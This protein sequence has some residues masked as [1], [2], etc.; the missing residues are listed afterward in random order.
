MEWGHERT[1]KKQLL[2]SGT[3]ITG[4]SVFSSAAAPAPQPRKKIQ[5][6]ERGIID[7]FTL[8]R[9]RWRMIVGVTLLLF[10]AGSAVIMTLP[11]A[12]RADVLVVLQ[13]ASVNTGASVLTQPDIRQRLDALREQVES[14][15]TLDEVIK[16]YDLYSNS[17]G[18]TQ[19]D[20]FELVRKSITLKMG[21][22]SFTLMFEHASPQVAA[23]V[24]NDLAR[25][26]IDEN[27]KM[28]RESLANSSNFI[29]SQLARLERDVKHEEAVQLDFRRK[30]EGS[31]PEDVPANQ[32][33]LMALSNQVA[34]TETNLDAE[35]VRKRK[36]EERI[37]D[38]MLNEIAEH[39]RNIKHL[40]HTLK[41]Y[42]VL[43]E[44]ENPGHDE[45]AAISTSFNDAG[46]PRRQ[47]PLSNAKQQQ[48]I[49]DRMQVVERSLTAAKILSG[50][51][52][53][54]YLK[55]KKEMA[56]L[57]EQLS[58]LEA[59]AKAAPK[60]AQPVFLANNDNDDSAGDDTELEILR[61]Q[62]R[63]KELA[64]KEAERNVADLEGMKSMIAGVVIEKARNDYER[65]KGELKIF[66]TQALQN[67]RREVL[68]LK[69]NEME[70][71]ALKDF[72][73]YWGEIQIKIQEIEAQ[74]L[75]ITPGAT[76]ETVEAATK[77]IDA[78]TTELSAMKKSQAD[79]FAGLFASRGELAQ[80]IQ[81]D[82]NVMVGLSRQ[83]TDIQA[84]KT[85]IFE[86]DRRLSNSAKVQIEMPEM[87]RRL[88]TVTDQYEAMLKQKMQSD[89]VAGVEDL[90]DGDRMFIWDPA[91]RNMSPFKPKYALLFS[92]SFIF[93]LC[94]GIGLALLLELGSPKFISSESLQRQTGLEVLARFDE[95]SRRDLPR[96]LPE[97]LPSG[98][99]KVITLYD[100]WNRLSKQFMD[101]SCMLFKPQGPWPR[102]V[103]VCS[104]GQGDGKTFV[105]SNLASALAISNREPTL[106]VDANLRAPAL[107]TIFGKPL[108]NGLAEVLEGNP[109]N[110]H[111]LTC[112][113]QCDLQVLTAG[114]PKRHGAVLLGSTRFREMIDKLT[115]Q[116]VKPRI[117]LDT[118][119]LNGGADVDVLLDCVDGVV[120]VV[121]RGH[122]TIADVLR[123]LR[124]IP[125][126]KVLGVVFNGNTESY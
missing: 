14:R 68:R 112:G 91:I 46:E 53:P 39:Q 104:P 54:E 55:Q 97:G 4:Y 103:A 66:R 114:C 2:G 76:E 83:Q 34:Q 8:M 43:E 13:P 121:R 58:K 125:P 82:E 85:R 106:L 57:K 37:T 93:S 16:K 81:E 120:L 126:E 84:A 101:C 69:S 79:R 116:G 67:K 111:P 9:R 10:I 17:R 5:A 24:A 45:T 122:T 29:A 59:E 11:P 30:H 18:L 65:V 94:V 3:G 80:Q 47:A 90:Q 52:A 124:R 89:L 15:R 41:N 78:M 38:L 110:A 71:A 42:P 21:K 12:Y 102:V 107:H 40:N 86:L 108:E 20:I 118:P 49:K 25:H 63:M 119:A 7:Y 88:R 115:Y 61:E 75:R 72:Q 35:K 23:D 19:D 62:L 95:L 51:S 31:L 33:M 70:L 27:A 6:E 99:A 50:V 105:A 1:M 123:S 44:Y 74:R 98:C 48:T 56:D 87:Q 32:A 117:I 96:P 73:K 22:S 92:G 77:R 64:V 113:V 28:R 36:I 100:P 26:Y 109:I 60:D